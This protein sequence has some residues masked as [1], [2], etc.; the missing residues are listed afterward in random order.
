MLQ[1]GRDRA[2]PEMVGFV[3][4]PMSL[5]PCFNG[6]GTERSRKLRCRPRD[7]RHSRLLQWGRDRAVPEITVVSVAGNVLTVLQWGRDRAVPEMS[8]SS[9]KFSGR[10]RFNGAGTERSRKFRP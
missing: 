1:W 6:A 9:R 4:A 5:K 8:N 3:S 2:V 10:R 7:I